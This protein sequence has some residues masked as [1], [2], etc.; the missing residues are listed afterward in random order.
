MPP[1]LEL[2][3]PLPAPACS[4]ELPLPAPAP[5]GEPALPPGASAAGEPLQARA[6][7]VAKRANLDVDVACTDG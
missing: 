7:N 5:L 3:P 1:A 4:P 6:K 2:P